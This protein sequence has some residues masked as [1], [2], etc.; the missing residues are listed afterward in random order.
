MAIRSID[1]MNVMVFQR[2][3]RKEND[4]PK[5]T[6]IQS[7]ETL[8]DGFH[9]DFCDGINVLIGENGVGKTSLLKMIYAAPSPTAIILPS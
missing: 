7:G 9:I 3:W 5:A 2:Q 1:V 6:P 8:N 4:D